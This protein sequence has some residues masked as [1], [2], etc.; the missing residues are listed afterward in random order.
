VKIKINQSLGFGDDSPAS[1]HFWEKLFCEAVDHP[2]PSG[3]LQQLQMLCRIAV[4]IYA[5]ITSR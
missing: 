4:L 2:R 1:S 3:I 5:I